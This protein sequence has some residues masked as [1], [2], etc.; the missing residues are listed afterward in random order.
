MKPENILHTVVFSFNDLI[1][2]VIP[3]SLLVAGLLAIHVGPLSDK[4]LTQLS[5]IWF[6]GLL[7]AFGSGHLL[8]AAYTMLVEKLLQPLCIIPTM[9]FIQN[10]IKESQPFLAF[11]SAVEYR[12]KYQANLLF[13]SS[14][15]V[16]DIRA[17]AMSISTEASAVSRRFMFISLLCSGLGTALLTL[18]LDLLILTLWFPDL[19]PLHADKLRALFLVA[20]LL[21]AAYLFFV[22]GA[23]F[24]RRALSS[25]FSIALATLLY[26]ENKK[27]A[28]NG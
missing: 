16:N 7:I 26:S 18:A 24:H 11:C 1:G 19:V 17:L 27:E 3:G 6:A 15:S 23:D 25:P 4:Q 28:V 5:S 8:A 20:L 22:R 14:W 12:I 13:I 9:T 2:A 21:V 10:Q